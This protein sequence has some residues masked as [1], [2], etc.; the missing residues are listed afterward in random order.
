MKQNLTKI[1][2]DLVLDQNG[3]IAVTKA[4]IETDDRAPSQWSH[5]ITVAKLISN[6][7]VSSASNAVCLSKQVCARILLNNYLTFVFMEL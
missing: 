1:L 6:I 7:F 5:C 3:I 4:V 2:A